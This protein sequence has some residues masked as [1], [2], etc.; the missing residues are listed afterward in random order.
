MFNKHT[1]IIQALVWY[2]EAL[3]FDIRLSVGPEVN[4]ILNRKDFLSKWQQIC[5]L[6]TI[7]IIIMITVPTY[8]WCQ[9]SS[10]WRHC[11]SREDSTHSPPISTW[12]FGFAPLSSDHCISWKYFDDT[13]TRLMLMWNHL[14]LPPDFWLDWDPCWLLLQGRCTWYIVAD[15]RRL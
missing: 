2:L 9:F 5:I 3:V 14:L 12:T 8:T 4:A 11:W 13:G 1:T 6:S 7:T 10:F 15:K